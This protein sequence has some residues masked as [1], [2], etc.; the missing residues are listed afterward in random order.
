MVFR[1]SGSSIVLPHPRAA[2]PIVNAAIDRVHWLVSAWRAFVCS[3]IRFLISMFATSV[4]YV[5]PQVARQPGDWLP[6]AREP[7]GACWAL[8]ARRERSSGRSV[9]VRHRLAHA[10]V[11]PRL[12]KGSLPSLEGLA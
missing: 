3:S 1:F 7:R 11:R 5:R 4:V 8:G 9:A 2:I 6:G 12:S 10:D